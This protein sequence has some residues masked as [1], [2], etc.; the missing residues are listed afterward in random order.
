MR[1]KGSQSRRWQTVNGRIELWRTRFHGPGGSDAP[2]DGLID[3]AQ[4]A[5]SVGVAEMACRLDCGSR[6]F[7]RTATNLARAAQIV[8]SKDVV[9]DLVE[10]EGFRVL[11]AKQAGRLPAGW[12]A[13]DCKVPAPTPEAAPATAK[14]APAAAPAAA[15]PAAITRVY[16]GADGVMVPIVTDAEK[17]KRRETVK[18]KRRKAAAEGKP[19]RPLPPG[20]PGADNG[21]KEFKIVEYYDEGL[22]RRH[23]SGTCGDCRAAG[24]IMRRDAGLIGL[25]AADDRA[26]VFDGAEWILNQV[27]GWSLPLEPQLDFYHFSEHVHQ[28]RRAVFGEDAG[29]GREW[30]GRMLHAAKHDGPR[31]LRDE[32]TAW[33]A[34]LRSPAK[35]RAADALLHYVSQRRELMA[36]PEFLAKGR[37]IGSGSTES[38]CKTTTARLKSG[39]KWDADNAE[40]VM[41]LTC[42]EQ[43]GQWDAW[44][45]A[46]LA[47]T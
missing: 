5:V 29:D 20:R 46:R 14:P 22:S 4:S 17:S 21:F 44:W 38:M 15:K 39:R 25:S 12:K 47:A 26:A 42:L 45:S 28:A 31:T 27:K 9:L 33:R 10:G 6:S 13:A 16:M 3:A 11:A 34:K 19:L 1:N 2:A 7:A 30:A 32:L 8:L 18:A 23:V 24:R 43:S 35:K 41:A 36:Y 37:H 40:A